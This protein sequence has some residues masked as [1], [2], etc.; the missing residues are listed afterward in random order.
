MDLGVIWIVSSWNVFFFSTIDDQKVI[1]PCLFAVKF[2]SSVLVLL[3]NV[4]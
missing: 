3:S 2:S 1:Y 4:L